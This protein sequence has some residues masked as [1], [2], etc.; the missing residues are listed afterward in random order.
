MKAIREGLRVGIVSAVL[1]VARASSAQAPDTLGQDYANAWAT[2]A[3]LA[4]S[5]ENLAFTIY[6]CIKLENEENPSGAAVA[7][8][9]IL[10]APASPL[11]IYLSTKSDLD[12]STQHLLLGVGLW[13]AGLV[14]HGIVYAIVLLSTSSTTPELA[15]ADRLVER[16]DRRNRIERS[17][18]VLPVV[19]GDS[20]HSGIGLTLAGRF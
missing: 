14:V 8:E 5:G 17:V 16:E 9:I 1:L 13:S 11:L 2:A 15:P 19:M 20:N 6:D 3:G 7:A 10:N 4:W 18:S 12:S